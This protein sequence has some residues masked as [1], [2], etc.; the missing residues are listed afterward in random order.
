MEER[1][2]AILPVCG[3]QRMSSVLAVNRLGAACC[4]R[5]PA[6]LVPAESSLRAAA[7]PVLIPGT[8][9]APCTLVSSSP[10]P[11]RTGQPPGEHNISCSITA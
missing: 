5:V 11:S 4:R 3:R 1:E 9:P 6:W 7:L 2:G 10:S 8:Y